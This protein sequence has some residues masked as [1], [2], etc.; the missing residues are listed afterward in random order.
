MA[1]R[2]DTIATELTDDLLA[3]GYAGMS[4]AAAAEDLNTVYRTRTRATV[5][6]TEVYQAIDQA[7]WAGLTAAQQTEIW[8]ILHLG[9]FTPG[10]REQSR[11]VAIF[12]GGSDTITALAGVK[13]EDISRAEELG[14]PDVRV[15]EVIEARK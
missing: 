7:E 8:N 13:N 11:F 5:T 10:G 3:R 15:G 1:D 12:G 4:D 14:V 6:A 9:T 2:I